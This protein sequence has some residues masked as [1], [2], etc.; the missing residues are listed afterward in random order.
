MLSFGG[1]FV[2]LPRSS[3]QEID[4][5]A[6]LGKRVVQKFNN[7]P[8]RIDDEAVLRSGTEIHIYRVERSEGEKLWLESERDGPDGWT[9]PDQL[10]RIDD[11]LDYFADRI[12]AHPDDVFFYAVRAALWLD[13]KDLD[14]ALAD[15]TKIVELEPD[16]VCSYVGRGGVWL[17]KKQWDKAIADYDKAIRLDPDDAEAYYARAWAWQRKGDNAKATADYAAGVALDPQYGQ[18]RGGKAAALI[19]GDDQQK[20]VDD[21]LRAVPLEHAGDI[22]TTKKA[23]SR[24]KEDN[25]VPASFDPKPAPKNLGGN[26]T[27]SPMDVAPNAGAAPALSRDMFGVFDPQTAQEFVSRAADWLRIKQLDKAIA[28][29]DKAIDLGSHDPRARLF[30]G[31]AWFDKKQYDKAIVDQT[32]VIR[33]DPQNAFAYYAR[34]SAWGMKRQYERAIA[35]LS[36]STRHEPE[37]PA[38]LNGLAWIWATCPDA[39][40]RDGH[41]AVE[42]A[43]KACELTEWQEPGVIDTLAAAYAEIGDFASAIKWQTKAVELETDAQNK[44]EFRQRLQLFRAKKAYRDTK[45]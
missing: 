18:P 25:V 40:Y 20:A 31:M 3:A 41:K 29:C 45:S 28:D 37:N 42:S 36:D 34:G 12:R 32:E 22:G 10:V 33:L 35:D 27:A 11:A 17:S 2:P 8:L 15:W 1:T 38:A 21:F 23:S 7:F 44:D 13:R 6:W 43:T 24:S 39:K 9:T 19:D 4:A 16:D 26:R 14:H 30:R 5:K